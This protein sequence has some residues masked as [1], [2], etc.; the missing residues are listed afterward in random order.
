MEIENNDNTQISIEN[1]KES[2]SKENIENIKNVAPLSPN[3]TQQ[4]LEVPKQSTQSKKQTKDTTQT[5]EIPTKT[6]SKIPENSGNFEESNTQHRQPRIQDRNQSTKEK[7]Q[8]LKEIYNR[9]QL[10][11]KRYCNLLD[12]NKQYY[13]YIYHSKFLG[14]FTGN[15]TFYLRNYEKLM[16][17]QYKLK[18]RAQN[19]IDNQKKQLKLNQIE[20]ML[21]ENNDMLPSSQIEFSQEETKYVQC[22]IK[23]VYYNEFCPNNN[24]LLDE[25]KMQYMDFGEQ[26]KLYE[27]GF[28]WLM[29][30]NELQTEES[31]KIPLN[32]I[33]SIYRNIYKKEIIYKNLR[34][35][36][37]NLNLNNINYS[38]AI[39]NATSYMQK[40][41]LTKAIYKPEIVILYKNI[42]KNSI[43]KELDISVKKYPIITT[44][45]NLTQTEKHIEIFK[46]IRCR[47]CCNIFC[48]PGHCKNG[49]IW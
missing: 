8:R 18:V 2:E 17:K 32:N 21:N 40:L 42:N 47:Y 33:I 1:E 44:T 49:I 37:I 7:E 23:K 34:R 36:N 26:T 25:E 38:E 11:W 27:L 46:K 41:N 12:N 24:R 29:E 14:K 6:V 9:S 4:Q 13:N 15:D 19:D 28:K 39:R 43:P 16:S 10:N 5:N 30:Y 20:E 31:K 22:T 3:A 35:Y 45:I 48:K